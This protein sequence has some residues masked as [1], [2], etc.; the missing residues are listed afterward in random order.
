MCE[1]LYKRE[2]LEALIKEL[3]D[4]TTI[5]FLIQRQIRDYI[6]RGYT[7]KGIARALCFLVDNR[8]FDI[9]KSYSQYGIGIVK[10]VYDEAHRYYERLKLE[11]ENQIKKQQEI[12]A[13]AQNNATIIYCGRADAR[14]KVKKKSIDITEL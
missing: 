10:T 6:A 12:V 4:V 2:D 14:K 13:S 1:K 3:L 5:P 8:N 9:R 7:Y 11:K